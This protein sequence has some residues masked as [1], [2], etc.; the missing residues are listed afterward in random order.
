MTPEQ[1]EAELIEGMHTGWA[2]GSAPDLEYTPITAPLP[3]LVRPAEVAALRDEAARLRMINERLAA[4]NM[5]LS[6]LAA[7]RWR[8]IAELKGR[9]ADTQLEVTRERNNCAWIGERSKEQAARIAE[10]ELIIKTVDEYAPRA[11]VTCDEPGITFVEAVR[12][13]LA[14]QGKIA[15]NWQ[16]QP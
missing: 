12:R 5:T 16:A 2:N 11:D 8:V 9:L 7:D 14:D 13:M 4:E 1:R 10:L 15:Y 6:E 3:E